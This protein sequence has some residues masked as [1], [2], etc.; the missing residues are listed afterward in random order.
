VPHQ[1][2]RLPC[3]ILT[4][5]AQAIHSM[6]PLAAFGPTTPHSPADIASLLIPAHDLLPFLRCLGWPNPSST[7]ERRQPPL[8]PAVAAIPVSAATA[9]QLQPAALRRKRLQAAYVAHALNPTAPTRVLSAATCTALSSRLR[10]TLAS[11][12]RLPWDNK[13][14]ETLWRLQV[15]GIRA[16]KIPGPCTCGVAISSH[17]FAK[18]QHQFWECPV[19]LAIRS[20]LPDVPQRDVWLLEAPQGSHVQV[21]QV[22]GLAALSAMAWGRGAVWG[23]RA[24]QP[25]LPGDVVAISAEVVDLFWTMLDDFAR[26][27]PSVPV[28]WLPVPVGHQFLALQGDR[29]VCCRPDMGAPL[30]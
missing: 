26:D 16:A 20:Q 15:D 6:G 28:S 10:R 18:R 11:V 4:F 7:A 30:V 27:L 14:K 25:L 13:H 21:W 2:F 29:L 1:P 3:G 19:A 22:V 23:R 12:W 24:G 9:V 5:M 8:R 17:P